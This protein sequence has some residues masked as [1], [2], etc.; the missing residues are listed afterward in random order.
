[1]D[2]TGILLLV[3]IRNGNEKIVD[4]SFWP[5]SDKAD[6]LGYFSGWDSSTD[7]WKLNCKLNFMGNSWQ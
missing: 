5:V 4:L 7:G 6:D 3:T 1:M 2:E